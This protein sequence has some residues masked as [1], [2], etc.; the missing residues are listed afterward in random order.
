[1]ISI[2]AY[3]EAT[4]GEAVFPLSVLHH[5]SPN[6]N[7]AMEKFHFG[8]TI[9]KFREERKIS[10]DAVAKKLDISQPRY[11]RMEQ[12]RHLPE[13]HI[14]CTIAEFLGVAAAE[15][16]PPWWDP[17]VKIIDK[18][19]RQV[20]KLTNTGHGI[21]IILLFGLNYEI[22]TEM[23]ESPWKIPA[24]IVATIGIAFIYYFSIKKI[25][26]EE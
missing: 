4:A 18:K 3:A 17:E 19:L 7:I 10:Q 21:Y 6:E 14:I 1:M 23:V 24:C 8:Q 15:I 26:I 2:P 11:S 12:R 22:C 9:K 13:K 5:L 20:Y 16:T 25:D